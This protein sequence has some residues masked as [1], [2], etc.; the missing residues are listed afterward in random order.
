MYSSVNLF[1]T[2]RPFK[3]HLL[4]QKIVPCDV[5]P[6]VVPS[7]NNNIIYR[8]IMH[9]QLALTLLK[10]EKGNAV[11]YIEKYMFH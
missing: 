4:L 8:H 2:K 11:S 9:V 10:V 5:L 6:I 3:M 1:C 7:I